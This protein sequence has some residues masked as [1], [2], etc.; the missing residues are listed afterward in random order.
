M[1]GFFYFGIGYYY[2]ITDYL[3]FYNEQLMCLLEEKIVKASRFHSKVIIIKSVYINQYPKIK[4][5]P[6][7]YKLFDDF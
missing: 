6:K 4:N 5:L 2:D 7:F 3:E 1:Y